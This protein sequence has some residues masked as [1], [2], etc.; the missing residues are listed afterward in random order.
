MMKSL[1]YLLIFFI[2][3]FITSCGSN[4]EEVE[5]ADFLNFSDAVVQEIYKLQNQRDAKGLIPFLRAEEPVN[6]YLAAMAFASVQDSSART[7]AAL[8]ALLQNQNED[9]SIRAIAAYALGQA[10]SDKATEF[11]L[12]AFQPKVSKASFLVNAQILEAIGR[13]SSEKYLKYVSVAPDYLPTD[14]LILE[15]QANAIYRYM[16]R[17]ITSNLG[18]NRMLDLLGSEYPTSVRRIAANYFGR[19]PNINFDSKEKYEKF[20]QLAQNEKDDFTRMG[21]ASGLG[22][23]QESIAVLI[24]L[25]DMARA[26]A[27]PL[28]KANILRSISKYKYVD[29]KPIFL[30]AVRDANPQLA[31]YAS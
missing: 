26:E 10:G 30:G 9:E 8:G 7:I 14:T 2:A 20:I 16:L 15:G 1:P 24:A 19:S 5:E 25:Q 28:V 12:N 27:N 3:I 23:F 13:V 11:L 4:K 21:L 31:I 18:T 22:K 29:V 6:R 17:G